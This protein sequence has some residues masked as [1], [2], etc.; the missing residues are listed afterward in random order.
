MSNGPTSQIPEP[1]KPQLP[2]VIP[3]GSEPDAEL[4]FIAARSA[5]DFG[6]QVSFGE[7][8]KGSYAVLETK[9]LTLDPEHCATRGKARFV[10]AHE[11]GHIAHTVSLNELGISPDGIRRYAV[12]I[13]FHVLRNVIE[14]GAINDCNVARFP[15]LSADTLESYPRVNP[16]EPHGFLDVP[17]LEQS[18]ELLGRPPLYSQALAGLLADWSE[19]RHEHGFVPSQHVLRNRER[20]GAPATDLRLQAFFDKALIPSRICMSTVPPAEHTERD[21]RMACSEERFKMIEREIYPHLQELIEADLRDLAKALQDKAPESQNSLSP[22]EAKRRAR[23]ILAGLDDALRELLGSLAER[24]AGEI[25]SASEAVVA[26][27]AQERA[28]EEEAEARARAA[29]KAKMD[30]EQIVHSLSPFDQE[31]IQIAH[32]LEPAYNR[33][34][35]VFDPKTRYSWRTNLPSG[36]HFNPIGMLRFEATGDGYETMHMSRNRPVEPD[37]LTGVLLDRSGSMTVDNRFIH[38]RRALLFL[39]VL[40]ERL[41]L[42][43]VATWFANR[44]GGILDPED[45]L[46]TS[47]AQERLMSHSTPLNEGNSD[48]AGLE[49][50]AQKMGQYTSSRKAIIVLTDAGVCDPDGLK[51]MI[52]ELSQQGISVLHFG[53][54]LGTKDT[55]GL[56]P[57]SW[58]DLDVLDEGPDGFMSVFCGVITRLATEGLGD[59]VDGKDDV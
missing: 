33:L 35:E 40:Y 54:G 16:E 31:Y 3:A 12:L 2:S 22:A 27:N 53:L 28:A 21:I 49:Y 30:H 52:D 19:L 36:T 46:L 10:S 4:S 34:C 7:A 23:E 37:L 25:G 51:T 29:E 57:H 55:T 45:S 24:A 13:G 18:Y 59:S 17:G 32:L 11:G 14:D 42:P 43:T 38:A 47:D 50:L 48:G 56:Y 8:G 41:E 20:L 15:S 1:E 5:D 26:E 44:C 9:C 6:V 39:R 58:G